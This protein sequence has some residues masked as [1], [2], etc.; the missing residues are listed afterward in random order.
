MLYAHPQIFHPLKTIFVHIPKSAGTSI[1]TR[2]CSRGQT[3]GG[4]STALGFRRGYPTEFASYFKFAV[5]RDPVERFLSAFHYLRQMPVHPAL[6]N[7]FAHD[8]VSPEEFAGKLTPA[9]L[10]AI[11]HLLPQWR[12]V[13]DERG[14][15]LVDAVY[16]FEA[17]EAAWSEICDRIGLKHEPLA[18]LNRSRRPAASQEATPA[19]LSFVKEFYARDFAICGYALP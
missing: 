2:L 1:E 6:H 4:H 15:I 5:A 13:C 7:Q 10:G 17:M 19:V 8:C 11:V 14:A 9:A 16:R 18:R 12:F 3:V